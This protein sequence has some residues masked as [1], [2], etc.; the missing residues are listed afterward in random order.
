MGKGGLISLLIDPLLIQ[1]PNLTGNSWP[2][3]IG[4]AVMHCTRTPVLSYPAL[5][6]P[7]PAPLFAL[8]KLNQNVLL[9]KGTCNILLQVATLS[10]LSAKLHFSPSSSSLWWLTWCLQYFWMKINGLILKAFISFPQNH[11]LLPSLGS[12]SRKSPWHENKILTTTAKEV[13]TQIHNI[14]N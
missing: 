2:W 1:G 8:W 7:W 10:F 6:E 9:S 14:V 5:S 3:K 12:Y 13:I 4:H 11:F